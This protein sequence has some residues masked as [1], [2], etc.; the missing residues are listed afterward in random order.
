MPPLNTTRSWFPSAR[1]CYAQP[2]VPSLEQIKWWGT[3][4]KGGG[5]TLTII[6]VISILCCLNGS[7]L[8][9]ALPDL[10]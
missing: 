6:G 10:G 3:G 9:H 7:A 1:F 4:R 8:Q 5:T 2:A